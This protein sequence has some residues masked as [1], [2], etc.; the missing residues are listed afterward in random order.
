VFEKWN[1]G[2][3]KSYLIEITAA[4]LRYRAPNG[5]ATLEK[6]RDT[7]GQKGTGRW[8][9]VIALH[10]GQPVSLIAEAVF[11]RCLS[12]LKDERQVA[13]D[14]LRAGVERCDGDRDA[15]IEQLGYAL[16]AA[17]ICSYAQGYQLLR[18]AA[19]EYGWKL[20]FGGVA[21][22]WRAG[23]IIRSAFLGEIK[24]A[25][26]RDA[27]LVN[28]LLDPFFSDTVKQALPAW[29]KIATAAVTLGI[30]APAL[31]SALAYFDAYRCPRL[32]AN[33]LQA[34]RDFFGA[35]TYERE[36]QPVGQFYH[37]DWIGAGGE[38]RVK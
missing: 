15:F 26:E 24:S 28:L 25:F 29:R 18:A 11:A 13:A 4:I 21:M 27:G 32:P 3:L 16:Y 20:D 6:I 9:S 33:L 5:E 36:D 35:H 23:C 22:L 34:Q 2:P 31:T 37:T 10:L 19:G 14:V 12:A 8:A 7:A 1:Q 38:Q 17:K 30:P